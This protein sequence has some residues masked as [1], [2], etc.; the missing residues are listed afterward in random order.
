MSDRDCP[1]STTDRGRRG[2]EL[3]VEFLAR[4]GYRIIE[5]NFRVRGGEVDIIAYEGDVLCFVEVRSLA[6]AE[7]GDP[8]ETISPRK[9]ARVVH[10]ARA[11][12]AELPHPWPLMRFDAVGIT[13]A[14]EPRIVLCREA[15]EA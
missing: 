5:R 1:P 3:A 7:H 2:E 8:L 11:Y 14:G 9:I 6:S 13:G 4:E 12:L 10:A 15:F